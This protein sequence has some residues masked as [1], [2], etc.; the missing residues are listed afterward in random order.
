[1]FFALGRSPTPI[2]AFFELFPQIQVKN[3]PGSLGLRKDRMD[4][5]VMRRLTEYL[6][7]VPGSCRQLVLIDYCLSGA[8]L[9]F[10]LRKT[11]DLLRVMNL[12]LDLYAAAL[13]HE[14]SQAAELQT[15]EFMNSVRFYALANFPTLQA[16]FF[17]EDYDRLAPF[18]PA[19][20]SG[21]EDNQHIY[22][23]YCRNLLECLRYDSASGLSGAFV[24]MARIVGRPVSMG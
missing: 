24:S 4:D 21:I 18:Q 16:C 11:R 8:T 15:Q 20:D 10:F 5:S 9:A 6:T 23:A 19:R 3:V 2:A 12:P 7:Q 14:P 22:K 17:Q 1:M 13:A